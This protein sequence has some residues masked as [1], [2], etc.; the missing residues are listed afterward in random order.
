MSNNING[1]EPMFDRSAKNL[2]SIKGLSCQVL[3]DDND[4]NPEDWERM[5]GC[6]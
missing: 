3:R 6:G 5:E 2:C 4:G 1:G